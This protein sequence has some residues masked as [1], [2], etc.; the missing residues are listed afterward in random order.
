MAVRAVPARRRDVPRQL[1]RRPH[2]LPA[3]DAWSTSSCASAA[4][5]P[6]SSACGRPTRFHF[7]K[8]ARGRHGDGDRGLCTAPMSGS[9][10]AFS[11]FAARSSTTCARARS[12]SRSRSSGSSPRASSARSA[13]D[14]F[15]RCM[16][17][18]KDLQALEGLYAK[19]G[20]PGSSGGT[21]RC[22]PPH[23]PVRQPTASKSAASATRQ[24]TLAG[25]RRR[26][27]RACSA[28][29]Y[30]PATH[31]CGCCAWAPMPTTSRSAAAA[32]CC[33]WSQSI[34]SSSVRWVVFSG[35][36]SAAARPRRSAALFPRRRARQRPSMCT[37]FATAS[38][39]YRARGSRRRSSA[40]AR[41]PA[42]SLILTHYRDDLHQDH[43][44]GLGADLE[45]VPRSSRS[46]EYEIPKYDGDLGNPNLFVPLRRGPARRKV[47]A[48]LELSRAS[49]ADAGSP[50]IRSSPCCVCAASTATR[51]PASPRRSTAA[52]PSSRPA[53]R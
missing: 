9:M 28:S 41:V 45:H 15:W 46:W 40:Q 19:G 7:V 2:R 3:A 29:R 50:P 21:S 13:Y 35:N 51:R 52:R 32:R 34:R 12:W 44:A 47:A 30:P 16:D 14:G 49:A 6:R 27:R 26:L 23:W 37:A 42:R 17:T 1:Q 36:G 38:F 39:P 8:P 24:L 48:L 33:G 18:F 5:S 53:A 11:C 4:T 31:R 10:A 20:R 25:P 43:R 22:A